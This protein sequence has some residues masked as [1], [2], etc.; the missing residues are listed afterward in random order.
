VNVE[1]DHDFSWYAAYDGGQSFCEWMVEGVS[2]LLLY[3][4][5][6]SPHLVHL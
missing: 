5:A 1:A 4:R 6:L 3:N 2:I